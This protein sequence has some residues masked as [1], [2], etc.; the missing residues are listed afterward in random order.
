MRRRRLVFGSAVLASPIFNVFG[1]STAATFRIGMLSGGDLRGTPNWDAFYAGMRNLGYVEG[2]NVTYDRLAADG[3]PLKL[4][5]M[6]R[7][8]VAHR[9]HVI[10]TTGASEALAAHSA[11]SVIP[12]V[13]MFGGESVG[14]GLARTL[15]R[16]GGNVTGLTR[17]IP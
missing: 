14:A 7:D 10:V 5:Q 15:A 8:L 11:T 16:P 2:S 17:F 13:M 6:A 12:I 1:Q 4:T 3:E 9:P